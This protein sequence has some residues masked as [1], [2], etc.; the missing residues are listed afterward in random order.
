MSRNH[1]REYHQAWSRLTP[2]LRPH[3]DVIAAVRREIGDRPGRT[4]LLGV[5]PE[6][7][8]MSNDLVAVDRNETMVSHIW[9]GNTARRSAVVADW[10]NGNFTA[11]SFAT[12]VGDGSLSSFRPADELKSMLSTLSLIMSDRGKLVCRV[13]VPP[14]EPVTISAIGVLASRG[15]IRNFHAF[16]LQLMLAIAAQNPQSSVRAPE[17]LDQFDA[18]FPDRAQLVRTTGWKRDEIDT[19]DYYRGST[20]IFNFPPREHLL[21]VA[22]DVFPSVRIVAVGSYELAGCC[23]LLVAGK[24]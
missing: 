24:E 13:Y 15:T 14:K 1:R 20:V 21:S 3:P 6:L 5:T 10:R 2:P 22:A 16:K 18:L 12:C 4:L 11:G 8:D 19:I 9:P 23:P 17:I 7:A